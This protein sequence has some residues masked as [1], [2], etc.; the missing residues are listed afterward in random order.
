[1]GKNEAGAR[2]LP[3]AP[4]DQKHLNPKQDDNGEHRASDDQDGSP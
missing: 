1:M 2:Q 3:V 4:I